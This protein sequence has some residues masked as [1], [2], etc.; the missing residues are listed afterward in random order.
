MTK[1]YPKPVMVLREDLVV[2]NNIMG[3]TGDYP[4]SGVRD[5]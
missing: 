5:T 1:Q 2:S 3:N 4:N